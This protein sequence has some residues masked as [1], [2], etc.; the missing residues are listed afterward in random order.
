MPAGGPYEGTIA[1]HTY[2]LPHRRDEITVH[3]TQECDGALSIVA[4]QELEPPPPLMRACVGHHLDDLEYVHLA[5]PSQ[6]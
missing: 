3:T 2:L 5:R 4:T 6:P 1:V